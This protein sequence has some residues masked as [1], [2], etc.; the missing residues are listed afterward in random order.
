MDHLFAYE[1]YNEAHE[2]WFQMHEKSLAWPDGR[3]VKYTIAV[4]IS[5]QKSTQN[6]LAEAHAELALKNKDL[7]RRNELLKE[8]V[9]LREDM[10]RML[11]HDL[12]GPL[13]PILSLPELYVNDDS[14]SEDVRSSFGL[15]SLAGNEILGMVNNSQDMIQL[16]RGTYKLKSEEFDLLDLLFRVSGSLESFSKYKNL[17]FKYYLDGQEVDDS[18]E[19]LLNGEILL[20]RSMFSNLI[21]NAIEASP[22]RGLVKL[23]LSVDGGDA[24]LSITNEGGVPKEIRSRFFEKYSTYSKQGGTGLGT[25]SASL[26]ARAHGGK[27]DLDSSV[28]DRTT[29]VVSL[30]CKGKGQY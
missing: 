27:I 16:E 11:H 15:I 19:F 29:V 10:E 12:K 9:R 18:T 8:N 3:I 21:K 23:D 28:E 2:Q 24:Y 6:Q 22:D 14:I 26:I 17:E 5:S 13:N 7:R 20:C 1:Y 30:S 4:D 25:Y